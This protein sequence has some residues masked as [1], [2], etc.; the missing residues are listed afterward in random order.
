MALGLIDKITNFLIPV[1]EEVTAPDK[2]ELPAAKEAAAQ[3]NER[4]PKLKVHSQSAGN[5]KVIVDLPTDF[6][7]V[8]AYADYL[9][10]SVAV[11]VNYQQVDIA[12][13]QRMSDFLNGVCYVLGGSVQLISEQVVLY[14]YAN[15]E[16]DKKIFSYSVPTY[17]RVKND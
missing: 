10:N 1:D 4:R 11:V 12:T 3:D 16:V 5:L 2:A 14:A 8:Q 6:D 7:D 17:V 13:Q 15:I 9:R